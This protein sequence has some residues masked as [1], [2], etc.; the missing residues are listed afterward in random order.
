MNQVLGNKAPLVNSGFFS[1]SFRCLPYC[2]C[3]CQ[4]LLLSRLPPGRQEETR[5]PSHRSGPQEILRPESPPFG[6][7]G[8]HAQVSG[9]LWAQSVWYSGEEKMAKC[10]SLVWY[11]GKFWSFPCVP[12]FQDS[13]TVAPC[14]LSKTDIASR[15]RQNIDSSPHLPLICET[16]KDTW[17]LSELKLKVCLPSLCDKLCIN[18]LWKTILR[19]ESLLFHL[20]V[21]RY[22]FFSYILV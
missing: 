4:Q 9:C 16:K 6:A 8:G 21:L 10:S 5:E 1:C 19:D 3:H 22:N 11:T 20:A 7:C 18:F 13:Q 12:A 17:I 15:G 2:Q 14:I